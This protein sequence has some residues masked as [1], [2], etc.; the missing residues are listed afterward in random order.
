[1]KPDRHAT[2]PDAD[3]RVAARVFYTQFCAFVQEG[4]TEDQALKLIGMMIMGAQS[5]DDA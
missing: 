5:G 1:M 4:F 3:Q 2:E